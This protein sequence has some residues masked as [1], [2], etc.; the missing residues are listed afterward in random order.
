MKLLKQNLKQLSLIALIF[1]TLSTGFYCQL[2]K[3]QVKAFPNT[4]AAP[5]MEA[6]IP[7]SKFTA[8]LLSK[9]LFE[10]DPQRKLRKSDFLQALKFSHYKLTRGETEQ[11]FIFADQDHDDQVDQKEWD[12]FVTLFIQPFEACDKNHDFILSDEEF[13]PCFDADP[14]STLVKFRRRFEEKKHTLLM[15]VVSTRGKS[16][17]NFSDYLFLKRGLF[18]WQQCQS[19]AK[20]IA[21]SQFKCA[22]RTAIPSKYH[23]KLD[24]EKI[25]NTGLKLANDKALIQLDF[26][27]YQRVLYLAFV[28]FMIGQPHDT[29]F[30]EKQQFIKFIK[31]D[32]YPTN[33]EESE[34]NIFYDLINA[35][36]FQNNFTMN[37]ETF[38]FF[39]NLHK[40]FNQYAIE[41]P[42]QINQEELA[43]LLDDFLSPLGVTLSVDLSKTNF[44]PE[45]YQEA[46]IV[47]QRLRVNERDFYFSF[48]QDA[49]VNTHSLHVE[50][51]KAATYYDKKANDSNRKVF[52]SIM[53]GSDKKYWTKD[54]FYK[55]FTLSNL[56]TELCVDKRWLVSATTF[57]DKLTTIYD[58]IN[59]PIA[60]KLRNNY[61]IYKG[62]PREINIDL[63]TFLA[64]ENFAFKVNIEAL[65]SSNQL[66]NETLLKVVLNDYGMKNMPD[67]VIDVGKKGYDTL[68]RR[69]YDPKHIVKLIV[70]V[71][72][73]AAEQLRTKEVNDDQKIITNDDH[74]RKYPTFS[75]KF[76]SSP[77]A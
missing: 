9:S 39:F 52:F 31:E 70:V 60:Q 69:L 32:R 46:S 18:A 6:Q 4:N 36:P 75:R 73:V 26:V 56:F 71:S 35:N 8:P 22:L 34:V 16:D 77:L 3:N 38:G 27:S 45:Q 21:I 58:S 53:A 43:K 11:I 42:L 74:S 72:S 15:N 76:M 1:L 13:K 14:K 47:L 30:L 25:Y 57:V 37:F 17:I 28:Y 59:P 19:H 2:T 50:S 20:Y 63:L 48:K 66:I 41:K 7:D 5:T 67:P 62:I 54:I 12:D 23:N 29:P 51:T 24:L 55:A 65:Y 61:V 68:R 40:L 49:S 44:N 64:L 10:T 33:F